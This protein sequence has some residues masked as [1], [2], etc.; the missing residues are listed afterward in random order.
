M[1]KTKALI[2]FAVTVKLICVFVFVY[3]KKRFFHIAAQIIFLI[4]FLDRQALANPS[5]PDQTAPLGPGSTLFAIPSALFQWKDVGLNF[6][7]I[8]ANILKLI[9]KHLAYIVNAKS[10]LFV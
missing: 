7:V 2:S 10:G 5:D 8:T 3:A 1:A 6:S 9:Q 4:F